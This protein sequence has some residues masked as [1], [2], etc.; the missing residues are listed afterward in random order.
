MR[1]GE[2]GTD[3]QRRMIFVWEGAVA[4]LPDHRLVRQL[5]W[6]DRHTGSWDRALTR[7]QIHEFGLKWMW[8][9][10]VRTDFRLDM[11]VTTRPPEFA[12]AL[13]RKVEEEN[14]P[15]RFVSSMPADV[16]GR[17]LASM[18]DVERVIYGLEEQQWVYGTHGLLL[19]KTTGQVV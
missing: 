3:Q 18:Y 1:H 8:T 11:V 5:E 7:W 6:V 10:L 2:L 12:K 16:L 19:N 13:A 4:S 17:R 15:I 14:W 9:M